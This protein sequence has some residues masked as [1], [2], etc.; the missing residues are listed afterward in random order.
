MNP[1]L[2]FQAR[3]PILKLTIEGVQISRAAPGDSRI[4]AL[5]KLVP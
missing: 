3:I 4:D 5:G 1:F 2:D